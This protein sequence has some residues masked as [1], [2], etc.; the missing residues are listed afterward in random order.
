MIY[1]VCLYVSSIFV[2]ICISSSKYWTDCKVS[3][4]YLKVF[5]QTIRNISTY[6]GNGRVDFLYNVNNFSG[7][8]GV[9]NETLVI[10]TQTFILWGQ[11]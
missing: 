11:N 7:L 2:C 9:P 10:C 6:K 8:C 3:A 1:M 4:C 5:T